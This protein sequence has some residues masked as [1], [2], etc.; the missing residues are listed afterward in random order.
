MDIM[1]LGAI[2][3][4]VGGVAVIGSLLFVGV[5]VRQN[6][7]TLRQTGRR[8]A[9]MQNQQACRVAADYPDLVA[10]GFHN[11]GEL[12]A[13]ERLRF[14]MAITMYLQGTEQTAADEREGLQTAEYVEPYRAAARSMLSLPGG[15]QWWEERKD[16]ASI[17]FRKEMERLAEDARRAPRTETIWQ[18]DPSSGS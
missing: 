8:Q 2:G 1:E 7:R 11:L 17:S 16:W 15:R 9:S 4:L 18:P 3:E 12:A 6:T 14:D 5:Q 10:S 13:A